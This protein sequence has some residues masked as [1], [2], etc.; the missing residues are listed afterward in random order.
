MTAVLQDVCLRVARVSNA[1]AGAAACN[2]FFKLKVGVRFVWRGA[3]DRSD[4]ALL[5]SVVSIGTTKVESA[6]YNYNG[7]IIVSLTQ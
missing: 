4:T 2:V 3:V 6:I 5:V 1:A 7:I